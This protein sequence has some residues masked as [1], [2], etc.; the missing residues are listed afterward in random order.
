MLSDCLT[1]DSE[2][3]FNRLDRVVEANGLDNN[4]QEQRVSEHC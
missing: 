4:G 1:T 3:L 2:V